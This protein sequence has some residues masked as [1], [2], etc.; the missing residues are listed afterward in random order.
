MIIP[1]FQTGY[2]CTKVFHL[3]AIQKLLNLGLNGTVLFFYKNLKIVRL[4]LSYWKYF[5]RKN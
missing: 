1:G 5:L 3:L 2:N 4:N